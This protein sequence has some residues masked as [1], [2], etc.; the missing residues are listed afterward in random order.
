MKATVTIMV[1]GE[2]YTTKIEMKKGENMDELS[3]RA[4]RKMKKEGQFEML[5]ILPYTS[6]IKIPI[7][8]DITE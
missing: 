5:P 1:G 8:E 4:V 2:E 7:M 3:D 6:I